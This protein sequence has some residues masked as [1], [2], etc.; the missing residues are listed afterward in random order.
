[1]ITRKE[2]AGMIDHTLLRADAREE[3]V[4]RICREAV[5]YGFGAVCIN[6]CFVKLAAKELAESKVKI[7]AVVGFPLGANTAGTK[8]FETGQAVEEGAGEIDM[9]INI[10]SLKDRDLEYLEND[11]REVLKATKGKAILKVIIET[12]YLSYEE[13]IIACKTAKRAGANFVKTSTGFGSKGATRDDVELMR[14]AVGNAIGVKA[15]GG[16][17]TLNDALDM[18]DAGA[19][20]IGASSGINIL[21]E[22]DERMK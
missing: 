12:C 16:I 9:V 5:E 15:A 17:K 21:K 10:S 7:C 22:Y 3:D 18:I 1:M 13:K 20:R 6:P 11:I 8:A 19:T 4:K 14:A 2:L